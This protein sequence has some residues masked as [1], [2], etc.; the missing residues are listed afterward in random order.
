MTKGGQKMLVNRRTFI[1]KKK[2][3]GEA[4]ALLVD[5]AKAIELPHA[6]RIYASQIGPFDTIAI[7]MEFEN[8]E[9]F[10]KVVAEASARPEWDEFAKKLDELTVPGG[11]NEIWMLAG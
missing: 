2:R 1:V 6:R 11:S 4:V 8:M 3:M 10:E 5:Y 9:E 7:E